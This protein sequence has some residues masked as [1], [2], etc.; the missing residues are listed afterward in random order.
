[1]KEIRLAKNAGFCFGVKRAVESAL[2]QAECGGPIYCYG[3]IIHNGDVVNMLKQKGVHVVESLHGLTGKQLLIRSHGVPKAVLDDCQAADIQVVDNTCPFVRKVQ[4]MVAKRSEPN[5]IIV[6]EASHPEIIGVRGWAGEGCVIVGSPKEAQA[7]P[8]MDEAVVVAQTT[9]PPDLFDQVVAVLREKVENL[10]VEN[11]ICHA[12]FDRQ[13]EAVKL[14]Q[15]C[16]AMIVI[17]GKN[18]SNSKKLFAIC[19]KHCENTVFIENVGELPLEIAKSHD[20]IGVVA[21]ASTPDWIIREVLTT[22]SEENTMEQM[23][24]PSGCAAEAAN[25]VTPAE[26]PEE[27]PCCQER[28]NQQIV[29]E[30]AQASFY[31][32]LEKS[33]VKIVPNQIVSGTVVQVDKDEIFV[34]IG[35]K[36]DGIIPRNEYANDANV[37]LTQEVKVGDEIEAQVLK[38]NDG[39]GNVLLS[40]KRIQARKVWID[41]EAKIQEGNDVVTVK[42]KEAVKG[43]LIAE[44]DG[45]RVFIPASLMDVRFVK[46]LSTFVDQDFDVRIIEFDKNKKKVVGSRK[47][48]LEEELKKKKEEIWSKF[49]PKQQIEGV[50]RRLTDFGAF[51]DI[52]GVDGLLHVADIAWYRIAHPSDVLKVNDKVTVLILSINK[53]K[54]RISL[55]LKQLQP[56]P[57]ETVPAKY[58]EGENVTGKV[59]RILD[60]GAF[61]ELEPGVDGL[62]HI[63][64][65]SPKRVEKVADELNIGDEI[66]CRI[67]SVDADNKKIS[68]SRKAILREQMPEEEREERPERRRRA[69]REEDTYIPE[70]QDSSVSISEFFP[71][72]FLDEL[73][74]NE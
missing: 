1:M 42:G 46:D 15:E 60:F 32:D 36:S 20:I 3:E 35:Y 70:I 37:D 28:A 41:F 11:T 61:V 27:K 71:Q 30:E 40:K 4:Q 14:A 13:Q 9:L 48:L 2:K 16:D 68:L 49:E 25:G 73:N 26:K 22:M 31:E 8:K 72:S 52:G 45:L 67:I 7:L 57:W 33:L 53:E 10:R 24:Q 58:H 38:L 29:E 65:V 12:T 23:N 56:K 5:V 59:V 50:V 55:G 39:E 34:N 19:K 51:V 66:E 18:S 44:V 64:Q 62:V 47:V 54:E 21:G 69:P 63:S 43:G 17:G 6:G 74:N